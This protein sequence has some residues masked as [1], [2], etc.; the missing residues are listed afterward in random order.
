MVIAPPQVFS[1][2]LGGVS[3]IPVKAR[4]N[5]NATKSSP[6]SRTC[7]NGVVD[8]VKKIS[9]ETMKEYPYQNFSVT[10]E[11]DQKV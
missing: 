9:S 7:F 3:L 8:S 6:P 10:P 5:P 4:Q 11:R 2:C 1:Y